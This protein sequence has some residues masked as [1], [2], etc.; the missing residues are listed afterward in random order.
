MRRLVIVASMM[1]LALPQF[2]C[3]RVLRGLLPSPPGGHAS[4]RF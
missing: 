4:A 3:V 1:G 2:I